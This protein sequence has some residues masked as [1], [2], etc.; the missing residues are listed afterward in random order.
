MSTNQK[1]W[2]G[3]KARGK[4]CNLRPYGEYVTISQSYFFCFRALKKP[5]RQMMMAEDRVLRIL[6]K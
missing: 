1:D 3:Q 2:P 5:I 6:E 4:A